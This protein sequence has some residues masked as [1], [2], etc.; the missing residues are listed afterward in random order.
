MVKKE[1]F[2]IVGLGN[3]GRDSFAK[4]LLAFPNR[5]FPEFKEK[6]EIVALVDNNLARAKVANE[7]LNENIPIYGTIEEAV[8]NVA[9]DWAIITT[10]DYTHGNIGSAALNN[11][12]NIIIDKPLATSVMECNQII[13]AG[14]RNHKKVIVG[15]N[16]RYNEYMLAMAKLV[17]SGAIGDV[18]HVEAAEILDMDHGG[19]YFHRWH[20]EFDKSAG[21][22]NHKCCHQLDIIN[23]VLEDSPIGVSSLGGRS[24]Y[25]PR[26][27]LNHGSRCTECSIT[28]ECPH[29]CDVDSH[30]QRLRKLYLNVEKVDGYIRDL[31]V[32]SDRNTINDH[33]TLNI[34]YR[35]GTTCS[36]NLVAFAPKEYAYFYFTGT[37][38]RLEYGMSFVPTDQPAENT[39]GMAEMGLS[40]EIGKPFIRLFN[41]DGT[42]KNIPVEKKHVGYG[43]GGADVKL[44]ATILNV[45]VENLDS[46]QRATAEQARDAVAIADM[47]SRSIAA[48]GRYVVFEETGK[49]FPPASQ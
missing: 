31:C 5:G 45:D 17:R 24:F 20:S 29:F 23:W 13:E 19:S 11:G 21:L 8:N 41:Y 4:A 12:L 32:F 27:D 35:K 18:I 42:I 46:I 36:F 6:S 43:H 10:P 3:R 33:E 16:M 22:M 2:I 14:K 28:A 26:P 48:G 7:I 15:H 40:F 9:A 47:S 34:K 49:D 30:E 38:G 44:I 37:K 39:K 1:R 25:V